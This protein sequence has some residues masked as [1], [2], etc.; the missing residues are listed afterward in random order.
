M[1]IL[2][3]VENDGLYSDHMHL[4][5]DNIRKEFDVDYGPKVFKSKDGKILYG[6]CGYS[7]VNFDNEDMKAIV[8]A[9]LADFL[10]DMDHYT[11][12]QKVPKYKDVGGDTNICSGHMIVVGN[13]ITVLVNY[14]KDESSRL[15]KPYYSVGSGTPYAEAMMRLCADPIKAVETA[16]KYDVGC[17]LNKSV[18][19][20]KP[21]VVK[22]GE[23]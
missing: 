19:D 22:I 1:T 13:G 14:D 4:D 23:V 3:Y 5:V 7:I 9:T 12:R 11:V 10:A 2:L 15:D 17:R 6:V 21:C 20:G 16:C 8:D 18:N